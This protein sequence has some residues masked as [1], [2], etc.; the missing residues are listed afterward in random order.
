MQTHFYY[1]NLLLVETTTIQLLREARPSKSHITLKALCDATS[2]EESE[3]T[4]LVEKL[5]FIEAKNGEIAATTNQIFSDSETSETL[6]CKAVIEIQMSGDSADPDDLIGGMRWHVSSMEALKHQLEFTDSTT[7]KPKVILSFKSKSYAGGVA[8]QDHV[9]ASEKFGKLATTKIELS[10][11]THAPC[12]EPPE[13]V[14]KEEE[15][16][17]KQQQIQ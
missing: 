11:S 4:P 16:E 17:L 5:S 8:L 15:N 3:V 2:L 13:S 12:F 7:E 1:E 6:A 9:A 10:M 14:K